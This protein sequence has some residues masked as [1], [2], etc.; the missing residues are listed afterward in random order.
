MKTIILLTSL[1][2]G[3]SL[4]AKVENYKVE[5]MVC[6]A[7]VKKIMG[8]HQESDRLKKYFDIKEISPEKKMIS[9]EVKEE[10]KK[11]EKVLRVLLR[12]AGR[13]YKLLGKME[14]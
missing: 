13:R 14:S 5:G 6:G 1:L 8:A 7:C 2:F 10:S 3:I 12:K 11:T 9:L 4:F